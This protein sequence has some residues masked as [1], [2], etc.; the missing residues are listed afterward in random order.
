MG[1]QLFSNRE[2]KDDSFNETNVKSV[3]ANADEMRRNH[4]PSYEPFYQKKTS[5]PSP[6]EH[7]KKLETKR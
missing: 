7:Y 3:L 4:Q 2:W 5:L 6:I 1:L